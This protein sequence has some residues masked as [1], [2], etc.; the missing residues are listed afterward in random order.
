MPTGTTPAAGPRAL[1]LVLLLPLLVGV[2]LGSGF[3]AAPAA[4]AADNGTWGVFPTPRSGASSPDRAYYFHQGA[5]G[6]SVSDSV[7]IVNSSNA[8]LTFTVFA[9][10]A[11]NT[12]AGGAF[13]LLPVENRPTGVGSWVSLPAEAKSPITVPPKGRKDLPFTVRVPADALPGDHIGGIVALNTAVEG[14]RQGAGLSVGVRRSVGARLY[15]RVPGPL[16][17]GVSVEDVTVRRSAPT[18]PWSSGARAVV[19]YTL[20][21]RGNVVVNPNVAFRAEGLFGRTVW[22][23]PAARLK[24]L[25]L[26]PGQR[27][28]RTEVWADA[29]QADRAELTVTATGGAEHP[30]LSSDGKVSFFAVPWLLVSVL[31]VLAGG[32]LTWW[33]LRRRRARRAQGPT[34]GPDGGGGAPTADRSPNLTPTG[35]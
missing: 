5:A 30:D 26:L 24:D 27:V 22:E 29:P 23:R 28:T 16:T 15:F 12:P 21:N 2:L 20:V 6:A 9:T 7:T 17:P 25:S 32:G 4:R 10:D 13:A 11:V 31:A 1:P 33:A 14:V 3:V 19:T 18:V 8:P 35:G 34:A